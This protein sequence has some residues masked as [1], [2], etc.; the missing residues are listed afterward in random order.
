MRRMGEVAKGTV[1]E[2]MP[3]DDAEYSARNRVVML[4]FDASEYFSA[5]SVF[6]DALGPCSIEWTMDITTI[7][8]RDGMVQIM[9]IQTSFIAFKGDKLIQ[10]IKARFRNIPIICY[11]YSSISV[12][13]GV[14]LADAGVNIIFANFTK[15]S[16]FR[17]CISLIR[18]KGVYYPPD[19]RARRE[20]RLSS[21][22]DAF[23]NLTPREWETLDYSMQGFSV[24][25][26]AK[27]MDVSNGTV[28][29]NRGNIRDKLGQETFTQVLLLAK[30]YREG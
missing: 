25:Q 12:T 30:E 27:K 4:G 11:S 7:S 10:D 5:H 9:V 28:G 29:K 21:K 8:E 18:A 24:K 15:E 19:V 1:R 23:K 26:I 22:L 16:E 17:N 6:T 20:D 14:R 13:L 3:H 2:K